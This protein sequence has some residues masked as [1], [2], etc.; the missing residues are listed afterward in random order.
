MSL[1]NLFEF[2]DKSGHIRMGTVD[3]PSRR[4]GLLFGRRR[5]PWRRAFRTGSLPAGFV[6]AKDGV[7]NHFI[8]DHEGGEQTFAQGGDFGDNGRSLQFNVYNGG[9]NAHDR[10][11]ARLLRLFEVQVALMEEALQEIFALRWAEMAFS[12]AEWQNL[13]LP[14]WLR[15]RRTTGPLL[16][17]RFPGRAWGDWT[18]AARSPHFSAGLCSGAWPRCLR[19]GKP[20]C[21]LCG[22]PFP[23]RRKD[24]Q[25][26]P[27]GI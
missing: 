5:L 7:E 21:L 25:T 19:R 8:R 10:Q 13:P 14:A 1:L 27:S 23:H 6:R 9:H 11:Q 18:T 24:C 3:F 12:D 2:I 17:P 22:A 16:R 15:C 20:T 26:D 4:A